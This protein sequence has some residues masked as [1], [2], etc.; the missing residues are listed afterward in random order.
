MAR[1]CSQHGNAKRTFSSGI[2]Q[3]EESQRKGP[4]LAKIAEEL[5]SADKSVVGQIPFTY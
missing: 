1:H 2:T 5:A 3:N 4:E